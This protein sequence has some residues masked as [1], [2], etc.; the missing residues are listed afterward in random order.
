MKRLIEKLAIEKLNI[1][2]YYEKGNK[3]KTA[4][5]IKELKNNKNVYMFEIENLKDYKGFFANCSFFFG[6]ETKEREIAQGVGVP[7]FSIVEDKEKWSS[8]YEEKFQGIVN[9]KIK[10]EYSGVM[11]PRIFEEMNCENIYKNIKRMLR[12][13]KVIG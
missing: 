2:F 7:S 5:F 13:N 8:N 6:T 3:R 1:V 9:S 10:K 11:K 4:K 12:E